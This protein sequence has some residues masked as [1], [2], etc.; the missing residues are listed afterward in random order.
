MSVWQKIFGLKK[1]TLLTLSLAVL[2]SSAVAPDA[3]AIRK[4]RARRYDYSTHAEQQLDRSTP[5]AGGR[6]HVEISHRSD[7]RR[8][9]G[10]RP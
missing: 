8:W 5:I 3:E 2:L 10:D 6:N 9:H 1:P 4:E 7:C